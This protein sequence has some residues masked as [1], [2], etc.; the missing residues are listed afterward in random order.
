VF[1][2]GYSKM[3]YKK[4][5]QLRNDSGDVIYRIRAYPISLHGACSRARTYLRGE[6]PESAK[7][8][9]K[10]PSYPLTSIINLSTVVNNT[11]PTFVN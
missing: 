11:I 3:G 1:V 4:A 6:S 5:Q 10:G 2:D 8:R 9:Q 7:K